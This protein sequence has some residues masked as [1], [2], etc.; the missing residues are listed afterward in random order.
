MPNWLYEILLVWNY[1]QRSLYL[2]ALGFTALW[3]IPFIIDWHWSNVRLE[4]IFSGFEAVFA[5][6]Q[7]SRYDKRGWLIAIGCWVTAYK[8]FKKDK[9]KILG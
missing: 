9:K 4:G 5:D 3:F 8:T 6:A 2:L 7:H 1:R